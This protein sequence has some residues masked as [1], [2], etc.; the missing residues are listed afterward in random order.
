VNRETA[1]WTRLPDNWNTLRLRW[2]YSHAVS[3]ALTLLALISLIASV[4][5]AVPDVESPA[6]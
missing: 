4:L 3:A 5:A 6:K 1:N 2:E